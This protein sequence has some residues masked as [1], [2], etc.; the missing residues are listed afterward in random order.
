MNCPKCNAVME[1]VTF[2]R[3]EVDRC[4][5]CK[6]IWFDFAEHKQLKTFDRA[7]EAID[8]GDRKTGQ[9]FNQ[10]G[11]IDCPIHKT[12][13]TRLVDVKHPHLWYESCPVCYGVFFDA[14]EFTDY[15]EENL[16]DFFKDWLM[17]ERK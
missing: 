11:S 15:A 3:I 4:T 1:K 2:Q 8:T 12:R 7:A 17:K 14:G 9:E 13:M 16:L 6:G 10:I 5:N